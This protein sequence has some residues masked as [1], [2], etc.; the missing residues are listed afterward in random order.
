M[1]YIEIDVRKATFVIAYSSVKIYK[2]RTFKNTINGVHE[3][4]QTIF[5]AI[6][7]CVLEGTG[8]YNELPVYPFS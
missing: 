2:M 6:H 3:F 7:H 8:N 4:I 1:A 5:P